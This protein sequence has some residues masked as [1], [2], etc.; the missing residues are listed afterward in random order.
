MLYC[1]SVMR[2]QI[3][4]VAKN[5][6][7]NKWYIIGYCGRGDNGRQ[8]WMVVSTAYADKNTAVKF[9]KRQ[10]MADASMKAELSSIG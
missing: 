4:D 3:Y 6:Q 1:S 10:Y 9:M 7:D 8:Q 2:K 5:P